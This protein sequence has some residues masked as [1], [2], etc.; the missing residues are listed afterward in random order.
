M[1]ETLTRLNKLA[2]NARAERCIKLAGLARYSVSQQL[3]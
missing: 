3:H 2:D 1:A